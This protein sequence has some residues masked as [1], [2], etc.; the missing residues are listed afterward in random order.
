MG[1]GN[2]SVSSSAGV[3]TGGGVV[4]G[5][6]LRE[7]SVAEHVREKFQGRA[8]IPHTSLDIFPKHSSDTGKITPSRVKGFT[9]VTPNSSTEVGDYGGK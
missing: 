9:Y 4:R 2:L 8:G 6:C 1:F 5:K 3:Y 7:L